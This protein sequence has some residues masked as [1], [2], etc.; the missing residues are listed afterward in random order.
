MAVYIGGFCLCD[1]LWVAGTPCSTR[2]VLVVFSFYPFLVCRPEL[3]YVVIV[4][5][6]S[7]DTSILPLAISYCCINPSNRCGS[8]CGSTQKVAHFTLL[9]LFLSLV[10]RVFGEHK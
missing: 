1:C 9:F 10:W 7:S 5:T 6:Q 8:A 4:V 2:I 3:N